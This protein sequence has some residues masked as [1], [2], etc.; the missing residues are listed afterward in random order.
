MLNTRMSSILKALIETDDVITS[1]YLANIIQVTSRTIRNS[2]KELNMLLA[3]NGAEIKSVRG[4]GYKLTVG[5]DAKFQNLLFRVAGEDSLKSGHIPNLP[6]DRVQFLIK[7]LLFADKYVKLDDLAEELFISKSSIQNDLREAKRILQQYAITVEKRP[8]YGLKLKG[9]EVKL[10]FCMSQYIYNREKTVLDLFESRMSIL[11]KEEVQLIR[12]IILDQVRVSGISLS[13]MG[14]NNLITHIAIACCRIRCEKYVMIFP[15]DMHEI[16]NQ[17]EYIVASEIVQEINKHLFVEFPESEIAYIAI[18]LMGIRMIA[19]FHLNETEIRS[20]VDEEVFNLA[21]KILSMIEQK[22]KLG[23]KNDKELFVS[24]CLHLKPALNRFRFGMNIRNPMLDAIKSNYPVAFQA[25]VLAGICIKE[26]YGYQIGESEVA[27]L[28]LHFGAAMERVKANH[29]VKR[30]L[31]VCASGVGSARLL[32]HKLESQFGSRLELAGT[33]EYY[34]INEIPLDT[35]DFIVSTVPIAS[36]LPVPVIQVNTILGGPDLLKIERVLEDHTGQSFAYTRKEL[37]FLQKEF[38]TKEEV[39]RFLA[40]EL[41]GLGLT[42]EH[43]LPAVLER[44]E[45]S[46]TCFG[47]LVAIPHPIMPRTDETFWAICTLQKPVDWDNKRVQFV[48]LLCVRKNSKEDLVNMYKLLI[49]VVEDST[50][51]HQLLKSKTYNEFISVFLS[52]KE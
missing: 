45:V 40:S 33:T 6:E 28:A 17:K 52:K 16:I 47:N 11:P 46:P 29:S 10:R 15:K 35:I 25:G 34:K 42:D 48:C 27:Y 31:I 14:L 2:I 24:M 44:E 36:E 41:T 19:H 8:N 4:T 30:C 38:E 21:K 23:I 49:E 26:E 7:R 12:K 1:E 5:D 20:L 32:Y 37:V 51:V 39:L 13:D 3:E 9:D 22:L 18:H 50:L 43:F